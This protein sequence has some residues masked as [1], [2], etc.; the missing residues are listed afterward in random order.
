MTSKKRTQ[1]L[2]TDDVSLPRSGVVILIGWGKLS[3]RYVQSEAL[4]RSVYSHVISIEFLRSFLRGPFES[5]QC[6]HREMLVVFSGCS[7][8]PNLRYGIF[9]ILLTINVSSCIFSQAHSRKCLP[10]LRPTHP[11]TPLPSLRPLA[12]WSEQTDDISDYQA[13]PRNMKHFETS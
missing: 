7:S 4:P 2:Y 13:Q 8:D 6:W 3:S 12:G 1:K 11:P 9:Y 10:S 5:K